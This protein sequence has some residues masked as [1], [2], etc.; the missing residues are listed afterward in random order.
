MKNR[1]LGWALVRSS[2][3]APP[4]CLTDA[5]IVQDRSEPPAIVLHPPLEGFR[6]LAK[7]FD[8]HQQVLGLARGGQR[9]GRRPRHCRR[10]SP[11]LASRETCEMYG[12]E[13]NVGSRV[14]RL[15][16]AFKPYLSETFPSSFVGCVDQRDES[17]GK[18]RGRAGEP[19]RRGSESLSAAGSLS[20]RFCCSC[21]PKSRGQ[22]GLFM[23]MVNGMV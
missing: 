23:S 9:G 17:G 8:T 11:L 3:T 5:Q 14:P 6:L 22:K 1:G 20:P 10:A 19:S 2:S 18:A 16:S 12:A 13:E 7:S 15:L 21:V 4:F